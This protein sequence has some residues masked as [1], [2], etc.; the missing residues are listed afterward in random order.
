M[1]RFRRNGAVLVKLTRDEVVTKSLSQP[2]SSRIPLSRRVLA[3]GV[4]IS[5][6]SLSG[7]DIPVCLSQTF[8]SAIIGQK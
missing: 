6:T 7:T 2:G 8:L 3:A 1:R 5:L 4:A